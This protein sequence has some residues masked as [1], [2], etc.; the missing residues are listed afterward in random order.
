MNSKERFLATVECRDVDRPAWWLGM[1]TA[2]AESGLCRYFGVGSVAELKRKL[3]D[4]VWPV[5]LPYHSP[6]SNA[7]YAAFD[8]RKP[9]VQSPAERT[10]TAPGYFEDCSDPTAVEAFDWPVPSKHISPAECR[11][12]VASLPENR[13]SLGVVWSAHF[14]D[15]C[16]AFGMETALVKMATEP[17]VFRAV[18]DRITEFY[19][20]SNEIFYHAV[21][22]RLDAVLIGNDFGCQTGLMLSPQL[23]R[24]HVWPGT[25]RLIDQ[26]KRYNLKVVHHSCGAIR[27]IIPDLIEMGVD[28][29]HPIQALARDMGPEGLASDFGGQVAFCG[30]V[31]AQ[32][33][34]VHGHPE[35]VARK[36]RE[37]QRI[38]PTGLVISPSH[39]AIL[40]DIPPAN[41]A[42]L[43]AAQRGRDRA[44]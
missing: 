25:R 8:F 33:L 30:G 44:S 29:I 43:A 16:A 24:Q 35:D 31:D 3:G 20:Q 39:E 32:E 9:G 19:L 36:V 37:L 14:Q 34:L 40:P 17:E 42:A 41:I 23:L 2:E 4:D 13:A 5:E 10:L 15:A 7:I 28:V 6:V 22:G 18:I 1:P 26:A 21:D 12:A 11:K 27:E 38:F